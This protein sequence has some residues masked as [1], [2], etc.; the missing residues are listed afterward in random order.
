MK[1]KE[2]QLKWYFRKRLSNTDFYLSSLGGYQDMYGLPR[3][4]SDMT[5]ID[6]TTGE[7]VKSRFHATQY[8]LQGLG[9]LWNKFNRRTRLKIGDIIPAVLDPDDNHIIYVDFEYEERKNK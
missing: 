4:G 8:R 1:N 6:W 2:R 5:V 9:S 7:E 3:L